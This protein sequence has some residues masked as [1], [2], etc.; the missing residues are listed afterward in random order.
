MATSTTEL[1]LLVTANADQFRKE[2]AGVQGQ[3][4]KLTNTGNKATSGIGAGFKSALPDISKF[5]VGMAAA[6]LA[7]D[8]VAESIGRIQ[9]KETALAEFSSLT[10]VSGEK[11]KEFGNIAEEMAVKFGTTAVDNIES[12][13]G[14][15]SRLGPDFAKSSEAVKLMGEN[16][17]ILA[18]AS[19]LDATAAMDALTT[20]MLQ[21]GVD[22]S[23]PNAAAAES[24]RMMNAMAA[25]AKEGAAEIPQ[26]AEAL[27]QTGVTAKN[28]NQSFESV[29]A[30]LQ[31]L[32][33]GGKTGSEAGV[34]LRNVMS[35]LVKPSKEAG[36]SLERIG[37]SSSE[38]GR[39]LST[40]G[41][42]AAMA[43]LGEGLKTVGTDADRSAILFKLFGQEN[44]AAA[45]IL[46]NGSRA[47]NG[48]ASALAEME[49]RLTGT[50]VAQEQS[51]IVMETSAERLK[52]LKA[53]WD[54]LLDGSIEAGLS[55][56]FTPFNALSDLLD[57]K[58]YKSAL[59]A[60][61]ALLDIGKY[62]TLG[63]VDL[64]ESFGI[65]QKL[66]EMDAMEAKN[67]AIGKKRLEITQQNRL[68]TIG[69]GNAAF[70]AAKKEQDALA[71]LAKVQETMSAPVEEKKKKGKKEK[72]D[73]TIRDRFA[74]EQL[75]VQAALDW[76]KQAAEQRALIWKNSGKDIGD[77]IKAN[78]NIWFLARKPIELW[79]EANK[80]AAA[81][82]GQTEDKTLRATATMKAMASATQTLGEALGGA[83]KDGAESMKAALK[84]MLIEILNYAEKKLILGEAVSFIE[85]LI[86]PTSL[87]KNIPLLVAAELAIV[88]AR[89]AVNS[90]AV[91]NVPSDQLAQI[92]KGEM[93][94]PQTFAESVRRGEIAISGS[95]SNGGPSKRVMPQ[96]EDRIAVNQ[97]VG[98]SAFESI[99]T[100]NTWR[101]GA[102]TF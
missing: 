12:F 20:A 19:G 50:T 32:A 28:L 1:E 77:A 100:R 70:A 58:F 81:A 25:G 27:K 91:P 68:A 88:A 18:K 37:L 61:K 101:R 35:L 4:D 79:A 87:I 16:I 73:T 15:L 38:L 59:K 95:G 94:I 98:A 44:A 99:T 7:A 11:L 86:N 53:Q 10:G 102:R 60:T 75:I 17:N 92:H 24:T 13:K 34:A 64:A 43:R 3:L 5:A 40:Q 30:A 29:N 93:I 48:H 39:T 51:K 76:E 78:A 97:N 72:A 66:A 57:G 26:I 21:F 47:V 41:L 36:D 33:A 45:Q 62:S 31:I 82:A 42:N 22:L 56:I 84:A 63:V 55:S 90:Y 14:V 85:A 96:R 83:A 80:T 49:R 8:Q 71:Q 46:L 23:D 54:S 9:A 52:R 6:S 67:A 74:T 89:T 2:L 65:N 69:M